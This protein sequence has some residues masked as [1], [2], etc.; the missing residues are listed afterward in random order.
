MAEN[1]LTRLRRELR[2]VNA[3][4]DLLLVKGFSSPTLRQDFEKAAQLRHFA[5]TS[6]KWAEPLWR[7]MQKNTALRVSMRPFLLAN[8]AS[9]TI[10]EN[11]NWQSAWKRAPQANARWL[12]DADAADD[13][14]IFRE[15]TSW[16]LE[17]DWK[18]RDDTFRAELRARLAKANSKADKQAVLRRYDVHAT[19]DEDTALALYAA[20]GD[21][22]RKFIFDRLPW[23]DAFWERLH[24]AALRAHDDDTAWALYRRQVDRKRWGH[25]VSALITTVLDDAGLL[26]ALEKRHPNHVQEAGSV[27]LELARK[28]GAGVIPYLQKH[29][30]AVFPRWGWYGP[31]DD[32]VLPALVRLADENAWTALWSRLLQSSATPELWNAEVRRILATDMRTLTA[33]TKLH[34]LA[35]A[36]SEWNFAGFSLAQVQPLEDETAVMMLERAPDVLRGPYRMHLS[37]RHDL[38]Y[39]KL[40]DRVLAT[41]DEVLVDFLASRV[42]LLAW[43]SAKLGKRLAAHYEKLDDAAFIRRATHVLSMLPAYAIWNYGSLVETNALARLLFERSTPLYLGDAV[44]VRELLESPQIHVQALAFRVLATDDTRA[45]AIAAKNVDVLVPT[46]LR[47]LH[48]KTRLAAFKALAAAARGDQQAAAI[49]LKKMKEALS[50]PDKRY[51]K[52]ELIAAM[53]K[54]LSKW[55]ALRSPGEQPRIFRKAVA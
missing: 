55:P 16:K 54:V 44:L 35:G 50:L 23:R 49:V 19:L 12:A 14:E 15:L 45:D 43:N 18:K 40:L 9:G 37:P 20:L 53:A 41:D 27:F 6:Q 38:E 42:T 1:W 34:A 29:A 13:I 17:L 36:G 7:E 48:R 39:P 5:G 30:R 2:E 46:L 8:L 10:D 4:V 51:P 25:D 11:G 33:R 52:E 26:E 21:G 47:P 32:K 31:K 28:R 22:A 3:A 24:A